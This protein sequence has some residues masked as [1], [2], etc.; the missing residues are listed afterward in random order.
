VSTVAYSLDQFSADCRTALQSDPGPDGRQKIRRHLQQAL[1]DPTFLAAHLADK[2][3][4]QREILYEDPDLGFCICAH[5]YDGAKAG[6]PHDHGPTWAIYGQAEGETEMSDWKI[7][8]PPRGDRPGKVEKVR[9]YRL[10]PGDAHIYE[11]GD[12]HAPLRDGL[13]KLIRIEGINT[14]TIKR[15][16]LKPV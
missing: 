8:E 15:T 2:N 3:P 16:L 11:A 4:P 1:R 10:T 12:V 5:I 6:D 9:S 13:T 14:D 7:V